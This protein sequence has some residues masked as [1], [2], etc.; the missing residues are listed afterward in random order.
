MT[1][2]RMWCICT[3][4]NARCSRLTT[5]LGS[6]SRSF[7]P[8]T[9]CGPF[10]EQNIILPISAGVTAIS[11]ITAPIMRAALISI[12]GPGSESGIAG[13]GRYISF[14]PVNGWLIAPVVAR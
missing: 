6:A 2:T 14:A 10:A 8:C 1:P 3:G 4:C 9:T 12:V 7:G 5:S 13:E 11:Q